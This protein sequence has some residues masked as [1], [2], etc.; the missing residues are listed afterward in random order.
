LR[1]EGVWRLALTIIVAGTEETHLATAMPPTEASLLPQAEVE[2][3]LRRNTPFV[4]S[5]W[6][7]G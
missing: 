5:R 4:D 7:K 3:T 1:I 6:K 2:L